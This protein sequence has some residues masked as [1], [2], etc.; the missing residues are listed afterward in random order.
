MEIRVRK[1]VFVM[2]NVDI[3][4]LPNE[5]TKV[6]VSLT[7]TGDLDYFTEIGDFSNALVDQERTFTLNQRIKYLAIRQMDN[8]KLMICYIEV[9]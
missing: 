7:F 1:I 2:P 5:N 4:S 9:F 6:L 3:G 8:T